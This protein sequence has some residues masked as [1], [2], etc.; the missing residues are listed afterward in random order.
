MGRK[1]ANAPPAA[2]IKPTL[3]AYAAP[4]KRTAAGSPSKRPIAKTAGLVR[5]ARIR[6]A[7]LNVHVATLD[8]VCAA[9]VVSGHPPAMRTLLHW[10]HAARGNTRGS[11]CSSGS[12]QKPCAARSAGRRRQCQRQ[13]SSSVSNCARRVYNLGLPSGGMSRNRVKIVHAGTSSAPWPRR[14]SH[15]VCVVKHVA[16]LLFQSLRSLGQAAP[17]YV[18]MRGEGAGTFKTA[19]VWILQEAIKSSRTGSWSPAMHRGAHVTVEGF[20]NCGACCAVQATVWTGMDSKS[21]R[22]FACCRAVKT[23][24]GK[25]SGSCQW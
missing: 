25:S 1:V 23:A 5:F 19:H 6:P 11:A 20:R 15:A 4:S 8:D 10:M 17:V 9:G 2:N 22:G 3:N 14:W 13:V 7:A 21:E 16:S 24:A 12:K 18:P